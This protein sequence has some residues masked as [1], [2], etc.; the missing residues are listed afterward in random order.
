[1]F[2]NATTN[3]WTADLIK[4]TFRAMVKPKPQPDDIFVECTVIEPE[5]ERSNNDENGNC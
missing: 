5:D 2:G 1:M 4:E 3:G